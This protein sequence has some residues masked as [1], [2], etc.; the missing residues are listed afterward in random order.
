MIIAS[1]TQ[2]HTRVHMQKSLLC[3]DGIYLGDGKNS[4]LLAVCL[5]SLKI[6]VIMLKNILLT[7]WTGFVTYL[8]L[9]EVG[10]SLESMARVKTESL[11]TSLRSHFFVGLK[12]S[13]PHLKNGVWAEI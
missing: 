9:L 4:Q 10:C 5:I 13:S 12:T 3:L 11:I 2:E 6:P 7:K 8:R 1:L